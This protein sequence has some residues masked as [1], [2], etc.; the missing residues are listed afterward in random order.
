MGQEQK[1][2]LI[3]EAQQLGGG[4]MLTRRMVL[5]L[6]AVGIQL[7]V[8]PK[9]IKFDTVRSFLR[10]EIGDFAEHRVEPSEDVD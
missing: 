6:V 8:L 4:K 3:S 1:D 2:W 9:Q 10:R 5:K 7:E